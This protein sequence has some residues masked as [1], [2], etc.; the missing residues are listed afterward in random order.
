MKRLHVCLSSVDNQRT[1]INEIVTTLN[2]RGVSIRGITKNII[3][4]TPATLMRKDIDCLIENLAF[5]KLIGPTTK[6]LSN[7]GKDE[8]IYLTTVHEDQK[9]MVVVN[10]QGTI[11]VN[12]I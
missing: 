6:K 2:K 11:T 1:V 8:E 5:A 9:F 12:P 10:L 7:S 4:F 3:K